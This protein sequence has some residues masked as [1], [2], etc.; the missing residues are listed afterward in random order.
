M[1]KD[2]NRAGLFG[3]SDTAKIMGNWETKTFAKWWCEKLGLFRNN[4][5][6]KYTTAGTYYEHKIATAIGEILGLKLKL[7]RQI[8]KR[9]LRVRVN[10]DAEDKKEVH[11]IKTFKECENWEPPKN[12][13][14][15]VRVQMWA[16]K[17]KGNIWGYPMNEENYKNYFLPI[18]KN[19]LV[20]F[21]V[22]QDN[23][24]I[25]EYLLRVKYLSKCLRKGVYPNIKE[26]RYGI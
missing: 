13:I 19:K 7:D 12:Y 10:L 25:E 16:T 1:I 26:L 21:E 4:M 15:Q 2:K 9:K 3:A 17:K 6:T 11:E 22:K 23:K 14:M 5:Q 20:R 8:K 18:D 24:F